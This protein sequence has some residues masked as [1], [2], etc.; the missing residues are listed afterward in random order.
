MV[1]N[2]DWTTGYSFFIPQLIIPHE[3]L[4]FNEVSLEKNGPETQSASK[5]GEL[6]S[7]SCLQGTVS[8]SIYELMIE[9]L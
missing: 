9:I 2:L 1:G 5:K 8:S 7:S 4:P 6:I 3:S